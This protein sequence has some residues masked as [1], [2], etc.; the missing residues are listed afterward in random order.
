MI[1]VE[2]L[3]TATAGQQRAKSN[4]ALLKQRLTCVQLRDALTMVLVLPNTLAQICQRHRVRAFVMKAGQDRVANSIRVR[5]SASYAKTM[6]SA[7]QLATLALSALAKMDTQ[8]ISARKAAM[9]SV[10]AMEGITHLV[11][12]PMLERTLPSIG[13]EMVVAASIGLRTKYVRMML[14]GARSR[15]HLLTILSVRVMR[16]M[17]VGSALRAI[18]MEAAQQQRIF[19]MEKPAT[20]SHSACVNKEYALNQTLPLCQRRLQLLCQQVSQ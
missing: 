14:S 19:P 5:P 16:G 13:V 18:V 10:P 6:V 1:L 17:T 7:W 2:I 9:A 20:Q 8:G 12:I 15:R 11:A 3:H 4:P